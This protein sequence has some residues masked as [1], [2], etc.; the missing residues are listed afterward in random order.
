M[1]VVNRAEVLF[2]VVSLLSVS[3]MA[4]RNINNNLIYG[5]R[6]AQRIG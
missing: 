3:T 6:L 2:V 4:R 5:N 1:K